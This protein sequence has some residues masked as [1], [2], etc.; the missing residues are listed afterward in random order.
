M[1]DRE[2]ELLERWRRERPMYE[3]WGQFVCRTLEEEVAAKIG[4]DQ[5]KIFFRIPISCRTKTEASFLAKAF[6]R[7]KYN[8][9]YNDVEDKVGVRIVVLFS[10]EIRIVEHVV[11]ECQHWIAEKARDFEEERRSEEHTSA[12]KSLIRT[13]YAVFCL[14]KKRNQSTS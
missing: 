12:L 6:H 9:P 8:D 11:N 3:C 14:T 1:N 7:K 5:A 10:E 4:L 13:P 2:T